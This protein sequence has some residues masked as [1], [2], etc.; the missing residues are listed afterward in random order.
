[1]YI[2]LCICTYMCFKHIA[3]EVNTLTLKSIW[4]SRFGK[5]DMINDGLCTL[6]ILLSLEKSGQNRVRN[7]E[8]LTLNLSFPSGLIQIYAILSTVLRTGILRAIVLF[9][10]WLSLKCHVQ[11]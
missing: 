1:M 6:V 3:Y 7:A 11:V 5:I 2:C 10:I 4:I 9:S 8:R